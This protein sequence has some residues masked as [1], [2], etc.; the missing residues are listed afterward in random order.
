MTAARSELEKRFRLAGFLLIDG[1]LVEAVCLL[2]SGPPA[3]ILL[4]GL[5]GSLC[6]AGIGIYLYASFC[7]QGAIVVPTPPQSNTTVLFP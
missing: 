2:W 3:F 6:L 5:G 4:A 7:R 1:L